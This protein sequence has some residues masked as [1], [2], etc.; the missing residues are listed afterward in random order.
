ME[1]PLY[2]TEWE[3]AKLKWKFE[4]ND[5]FEIDN[6]EKQYYRCQKI[7]KDS[8]DNITIFLRLISETKLDDS[9][10]NKEMKVY[11]SLRNHKNIVDTNPRA[12]RLSILGELL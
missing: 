7:A 5:L 8:N 4:Q 1:L 12:I 2:F 11:F 3:G 6:E 10:E 9:K